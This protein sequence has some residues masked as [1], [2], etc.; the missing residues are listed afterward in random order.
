MAQ[1]EMHPADAFRIEPFAWD[2]GGTT[3]VSSH[4][5]L[6]A[7]ERVPPIALRRFRPAA[8]AS[9]VISENWHLQSEKIRGKVIGQYGPYL[10]SGNWWDEKSWAR[11]ECDLQLEN[12]IL[13]R[14]HQ[15][16]ENWEIDGVYD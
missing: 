11:A 7:T 16:E 8:A 15:S 10:I 9:V 6:D 12:G 4:Y 1:F 14:C 2:A 5:S 3:S 13:C